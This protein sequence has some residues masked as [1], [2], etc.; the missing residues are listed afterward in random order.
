MRTIYLQMTDFDKEGNVVSTYPAQSWDY[1]NYKE[2]MMAEGA[3]ASYFTLVDSMS[4]VKECVVNLMTTAPDSNAPANA[5]VS[6]MAYS[7]D[8]YALRK[9]NRNI[10][11]YFDASLARSNYYEG[12]LFPEMMHKVCI[13]Y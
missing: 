6:I 13:N 9:L 1:D 4:I 5:E 11:D 3:D 7:F 2:L 10:E 8:K 12:S